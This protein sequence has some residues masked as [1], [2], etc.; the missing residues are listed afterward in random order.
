MLVPNDLQE[1]GNLIGP[2]GRELTAEQVEAIERRTGP[3]FLYANAGS[4]KTSVLVERFV[5]AVREDGVDPAAILAIT[6]TEKAAGELK[7]RI[8]ERFIELD[9]REQ[10]RAAEGA[11]IS[12]IHGFCSRVLRAHA[13]AAGIDPDYRVLDQTESGRLSLEAFD[14]ALEGLLEHSDDSL[15]TAAAYGPDRLRDMVVTAYGRLR[16]RGESEPDL[17][18]LPE[19]SPP[20][21]EREVLDQARIAAALELGTASGKLVEQALDRL[22]ECGDYLRELAAGRLPSPRDRLS[23]FS[24]RKGAKAIETATIEDYRA[25]LDRFKVACDTFH[26]Y[27]PYEVLRKLLRLYG[28]QYRE[29]KVQRS[30]LDF[31]DLELHARDLLR[32]DEGVRDRYRGSFSHIMVDEFQDTNPLQYSILELIADD[33]LFTVGDELQSIYGFRHADVDVFRRR[34][35]E[36]DK[37]GQAQSL[38]KNFRARPEILDALNN[39]Y[40]QLFAGNFVALEHGRTDLEPCGDPCVELLLTDCDGWDDYER[41]DFGGG[42]PR[43]PVWRLAEARLLAYRVKELLDNSGFGPGDVAVLLRAKSD[44]AVYERALEDLGIPTYVVGGQGY[45]AQQQVADLISYL[46]ALAN[47]ENELALYGVLAS[48]LVGASSDT[49]ALI[50]MA[51]RELRRGTWWALREAFYEGGDGSDGLLDRLREDDAQRLCEFC[52]HF[53]DERRLISRLSLET[54]I[55]RAVNR[56]GYDLAVLKLPSGERRMANVRK[57]MRLAR[58]YEAAE[59]RNLRGFIEYVAAQDVVQAVEGEAPLEAEDLDAVRLMTIHS[60]KGLEFPVVCVADLGRRG[61]GDNDALQISEDGRIGLQLV[62]LGGAKS[63]AMEYEAIKQEE[64]ERQDE[65]ERRI[66]YVGMTRAQEHLTLSGALDLDKWDEEVKPLSKPMDWITRTLV[67]T[68]DEVF[69]VE[70]PAQVVGV[71]FEG[72]PAEIRCLMNSADTVGNVLPKWAL[73]PESVERHGDLAAAVEPGDLSKV[74]VPAAPVVTHLSYSAL[75][76]YGQCGYRFYLERVLGLEYQARASTGGG[77][78]PGHGDQITGLVRGAIIHELLEALDFGSPMVPTREA[79]IQHAEAQG[80]VCSDADAEAMAELVRRFTESGLCRR[81]AAA[82]SARKELGFAFP[83]QNG[84]EH[85]LMLNGIVD[86]YAREGSHVLVVDYK[87]DRLDGADLGDVVRRRYSTQRFVYALA[88]LQ[89]GADTVEVAYCFLDRPDEVVTSTFSA[90]GI[91]ALRSQVRA[92][93]SP[94][95]AGRFDVASD[96]YRELCQFCP[97]QRGLCSWEDDRTMV[98]F[99]PIGDRESGR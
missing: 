13:L 51:A 12:T 57:L 62:S 63:A 59:G 23:D 66:F 18:E 74:A 33:N 77:Q 35:E 34:R 55:D 3:L 69:V 22:E 82:D 67:P 10:A 6:Y 5:R 47:P 20:D 56:F 79:I 81:L 21:A 92:I 85:G 54:L 65:E 29:L 84:A 8:R 89:A 38:A 45:W 96:P 15:E 39:A 95:L 61:R 44:M 27:A 14:G 60:A 25:A 72:R 64:L 24:I 46:N 7:D 90:D 50:R 48:P 26:A 88:A 37:A 43:A 16:S 41:E 86:V 52:A 36:A 28:A 83:L 73:A 98:P 2:G 42:L 93:A 68:P 31:D 30:G 94:L 40:S 32:A 1:R 87:S 17:P 70:E 4:G 9:D 76:S 78:P 80:F 58:Q 99:T 53:A 49:L 19:P 75:E 97:G 91:A 11:Y 71:S